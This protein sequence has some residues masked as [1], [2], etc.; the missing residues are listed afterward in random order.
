MEKII[1]SEDI[2][3]YAND[4]DIEKGGPLDLI[5][6]QALMVSDVRPTKIVLDYTTMA[7]KAREKLAA[8]DFL[9]LGEVALTKAAQRC[10]L[11]YKYANGEPYGPGET[12]PNVQAGRAGAEVF[13]KNTICTFEDR[14]LE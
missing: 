9:E 14:T 10:I 12:H 7:K 1:N 6:R 11:T 4:Q 5:I 13:Q 3:A 2:R 8:K